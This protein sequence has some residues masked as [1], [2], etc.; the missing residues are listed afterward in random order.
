MSENARVPVKHGRNREGC[1]RERN[2]DR[3]DESTLSHMT[4]ALGANTR[5]T[6]PRHSFASPE[7]LYSTPPIIAGQNEP[8]W[9]DHL[10][11]GLLLLPDLA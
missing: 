9:T 10:D 7:Y 11:S 5:R 8:P 2:M 1:I 4:V 6:A 3:A